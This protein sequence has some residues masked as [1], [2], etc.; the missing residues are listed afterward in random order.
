MLYPTPENNEVSND[1]TFTEN[2]Q[3]RLAFSYMNV[4]NMGVCVQMCM[5]EK[6]KKKYYFRPIVISMGD[7]M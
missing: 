5:L 1:H 3:I 4:A 6:L 7:I 2:P